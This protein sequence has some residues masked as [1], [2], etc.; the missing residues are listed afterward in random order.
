MCYSA[1]FSSP[2]FWSATA[3]GVGE[4]AGCGPAVRS[5]AAGAMADGS[6]ALDASQ[7][8]DEPP[9]SFESLLQQV[10]NDV[11]KAHGDAG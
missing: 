7:Q 5:A 9:P 8:V 11:A 10:C 3:D 1:I 4:D 2:T 6:D